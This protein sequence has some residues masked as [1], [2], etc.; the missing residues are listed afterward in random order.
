MARYEERP[1]TMR[2]RIIWTVAA[3]VVVGPVLLL[4]A[5]VLTWWSAIV[6]VPA[7][8]ATRSYLRSGGMFEAVEGASRDGGWIAKRRA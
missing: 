2:G 7:V 4:L 1:T 8:L 3:W 6:I 5:F